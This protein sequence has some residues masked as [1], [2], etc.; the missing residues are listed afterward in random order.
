MAGITVAQAEAKLAMYM[1]LD[2]QLGVNAEIT[3]D[4]TTIKRR[5]VQKQIEYWN[6]WVVRLSRTGGGGIAVR[7]VIPR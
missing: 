6:S 1:A 3:I 7:E 4:G 5:D 2:D